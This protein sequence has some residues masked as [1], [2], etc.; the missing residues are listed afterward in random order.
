[1]LA[2]GAKSRRLAWIFCGGMLWLNLLFFID[3]WEGIKRAYPD[4]TV[5]YTAGTILRQGLGHQL[6]DKNVQYEVQES[7]AGH[8]AFR[9]GPLPYI[10]PPFE[11]AIFVPLS[12][13]PYAQAFAVWDGLNVVALFGVAWLLR[14]SVD[15]LRLIPAWKFVLGSMAFFPV[16]ACLLEGQDSIL[17]LLLCALAFG[18]LK[19][20]ADL[21]A[22]CWLALAAFKF[23]F[24]VPVVLLLVIWKRSRVALGFGGVAIVLALASAG[25]VGFDTL[26][27]YP[28]YVVQIVSAL[29]SGAV[30]A[31]LLPNLH[32]L[33]MGWPGPF[34]GVLGT[35][36]AALSSISLF[37][38]AAWM[39]R[40]AAGE[41]LLPAPRSRKDSE[42][43]GTPVRLELQFSLAIVV[44]GL[45]A[46]QTN[47][48]DHSL[49]VLPL[50]FIADY[51]L[52]AMPPS[53]P[54][55]FALLLPV[56]PLLISPLWMV[57]WLGIGQVNLIAIPLL[58]WA[59]KIGRELSRGPGSA[60]D[61]GGN[62]VQR[63]IAT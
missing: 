37:L 50:V 19:K 4:F 29:G 13:L 25:L 20:K 63:S 3:F 59:W 60:T 10:H 43:W 40:T 14:R 15:W 48:H 5:F 28:R 45:I 52:L 61:S 34:S 9:H 11:A 44:S 49:L 54:T 8:I 24:I 2:V 27:H 21:L 46:W 16:F 31:A 55:R 47:S 23:Q 56:G 32:G 51:C 17:M 62:R 36:L 26:L 18:A 39:G 33:A 30:P 1:V 53:Q 57:L 22:G 12:R 6:Y 7:F 42:T 35:A 41:K 58:W 38:L